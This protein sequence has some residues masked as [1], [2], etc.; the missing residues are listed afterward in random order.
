M[1]ETIK[2]KA[3][4]KQQW[5]TIL[6]G[7]QPETIQQVLEVMYPNGETIGVICESLTG[8]CYING[9]PENEFASLQAAATAL[10]RGEEKKTRRG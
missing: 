10:M 9:N 7:F 2:V 5:D 1:D 4:E 6:Q 8:Q 3:I